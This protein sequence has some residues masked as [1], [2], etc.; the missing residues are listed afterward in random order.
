M[1]ELEINDRRRFISNLLK[2]A[3]A[4]ATLLAAPASLIAQEWDGDVADD[5]LNMHGP[6]RE[7][8]EWFAL[9]LAQD[10]VSL[11]APYDDGS[12]FLRR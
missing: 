6:I 12:M 5:D 3:A 9:P 1:S 8:K 2:W 10:A 4:G 7:A 11:F